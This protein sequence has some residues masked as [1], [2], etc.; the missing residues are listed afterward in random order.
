MGK[1]KRAD[2]IGWYKRRHTHGNAIPRASSGDFALR[3][4]GIRPIERDYGPATSGENQATPA[5]S[6][7][8]SKK[9][10]CENGPGAAGTAQAHQ[11]KTEKAA[12]GGAERQLGFRDIRR[13][14]ERPLKSESARAIP[15]R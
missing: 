10:S 14:R 8:G 2:E 15:H 9:G 13:F 3:P 12:G 6:L 1:R 11:G 5:R 7:Q 4:G